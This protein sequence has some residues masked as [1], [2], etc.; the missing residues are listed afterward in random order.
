MEP[1]KVRIHDQEYLLK[2]DGDVEQIEEI[3]DYVNQKLADVQDGTEGL[4]DRK[5]AILA[6]LSIAGEYLEARRERDEVKGRIRQRTDAL[7]NIIDSA[8]T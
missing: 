6:A 1:V 2:S 7:I 8:I 4:S 3:A 5:V